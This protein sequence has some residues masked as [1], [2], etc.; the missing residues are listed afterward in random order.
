MN[1]PECGAP[2]LGH[3]TTK[4]RDRCPVHGAVRGA[5]VTA[6]RPA[7]P[8]GTVSLG[9]SA[10]VQQRAANDP[11]TDPETLALL[12]QSG[13][14][15]VRSGVASNHSTPAVILAALASDED[16]DVRVRV[17]EMRNTPGEALLALA[18]DPRSEVHWRVSKNRSSPAD[19]LVILSRGADHA[20]R[21]HAAGNPGLPLEAL[22][23][24]MHDQDRG[25]RERAT[26]VATAR[27]CEKFGVDESN[28]T[29]IE[30]LREQ[31]WWDMTPDDP[32]VLVALALS[33]NA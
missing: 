27:L 26:A 14:L 28:A 32:T 19:A 23:E 18:T 30:A 20:G 16:V 24:M 1:A 5:A 7:L 25:M 4:S 11:A 13:H 22:A 31:A 33:P 17:A 12:A 29:A 8:A 15:S 9:A 21:W 10:P 2:V 3:R 6:A